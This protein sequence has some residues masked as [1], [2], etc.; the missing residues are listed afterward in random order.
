VG[1][2]VAPRIVARLS[3]TMIDNT[4]ATL[5]FGPTDTLKAREVLTTLLRPL[6]NYIFFEENSAEIPARYRL[7]TRAEAVRFDET[8]MNADLT[9]STSA[10]F[11]I[12]Q[13]RGIETYYQML[14]ILGKR[15][16]LDGKITARIIGSNSDVGTERG[17]M[18]LSQERAETVRN[19]LVSVWG[20]D[21]KRLKVQA[22]NKP[23]RASNS[24]DADGAAENRRVE[25]VLEPQ[26]AMSPIRANETLFLAEPE[27]VRLSAEATSEEE[28]T[29]W[30]MEYIVSPAS[31]TK[32]LAKQRIVTAL[33]GTGAPPP[34]T[35]YRLTSSDIR[36]IAQNLPNNERIA[37]LQFRLRLSN[38]AGQVQ[39]AETAPILVSLERLREIRSTDSAQVQPESS[40]EISRFALTFFDFDKATLNQQNT[41]ILNIIKSRI[42]T[43]TEAITEAVIVGY[44]DRVGDAA[45]NKRLSADRAKTVADLLSGITGAHKA[46]NGIGE[47]LLLYDN[48]LPEGRFYCRM[49][50]IILRNS[51]GRV[52]G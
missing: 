10:S 42:N 29:E 26:E 13:V 40:E 8:M 31:S 6:L 4:G 23:E 33:A 22:R 51:V 37:S 34:L 19:Y 2:A 7:L 46:V 5:S 15:L 48:D 35:D 28:F 25:I 21:E 47:S 49:V 16:A 32:N 30:A 44:T 14:N 43:S 9:N 3:A 38:K 1:E 45:Y 18:R 50:E 12:K 24:A 17:N 41:Q 52:K 20:I 27:I 11:R 36:T 39:F